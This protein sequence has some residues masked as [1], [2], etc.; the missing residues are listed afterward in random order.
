MTWPKFVLIAFGSA[1]LV[2]GTRLCWLL[3]HRHLAVEVEPVGR[4]VR[5]ALSR[6][7]RERV[8]RALRYDAWVDRLVRAGLRAEAAGD[9]PGLAM[10][11]T[12]RDLRGEASDALRAFRLMARACTFAGLLAAIW[13]YTHASTEDLGLRALVAGAAQEAATGRAV[14]CIAIGIGFGAI[15]LAARGMLRGPVR[16]ALS[17]CDKLR[18][19]LENILTSPIGGKHREGGPGR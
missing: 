15:A 14:E 19:R 6:G 5:Q 11:L 2:W 10:A 1:A 16:S 18:E 3:A 9:D 7:E 17:E 13:E 8:D 12:F 4:A